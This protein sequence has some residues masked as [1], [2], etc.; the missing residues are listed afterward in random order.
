MFSVVIPLYNKEKT[1]V[2]TIQSV[3]N[4]TYYNFEVIIVDDGST[5]K[6]LEFANSLVDD[7]IRIY[8][9]EH[10]G[11]SVARNYAVAQSNFDYIAFLDAD[12]TWEPSYLSKMM[13]LILRYPSCA[14]YGS[15]YKVIKRKDFEIIGNN[16]KEGVI[17]NYFFERLQ[18]RIM[19]TSATIVKRDVFVSVGG[20]PEGMVGGED[21]YTWTK[22]ALQ[23]SIAFTPR[24]LATYNYIYNGSIWRKGQLDNCK[25]SWFDFY[26]SGDFYRNEF[27]AQKAIIAGIRYALGSS[28]DK[29]IEIE[30]NTR[31]T[32]LSKS[33]WQ[34]LY[35]LNRHPFI[36]AQILYKLNKKYSKLVQYMNSSSSK[37]DQK[38][39]K[40]F[41]INKN[42]DTTVL[43]V[44]LI[45]FISNV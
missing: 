26:K 22:I 5:D 42:I 39:V 14:L 33:N 34:Y 35:F 18:Q 13:Q 20:F 32:Q 11:V 6:S 43:S 31:Y 27:V 30:K 7:R 4:Q 21:E 1:I 19:R 2:N 23:N 15:A 9:N 3:L 41:E 44:Y 40:Y 12:D 25:E 29:S 8:S 16:I 10:K 24:V 28:K 45:I 17:T 38:H 36:I 37:H